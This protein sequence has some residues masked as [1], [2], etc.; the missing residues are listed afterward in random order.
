MYHH[1]TTVNTACAEDGYRVEQSNGG[2]S[3]VILTEAEVQII[4]RNAEQG[5][6]VT[7]PGTKALLKSDGS[8]HTYTFRLTEVTDKTGETEKDGGIKDYTATATAG[9]ADG[10][11][12]FKLSYVQAEL[13]ELPMVFYYRIT[14]DAPQDS[15]PNETFYVA[16]VTL[17]LQDGNLTAA[18]TKMWK[19]GQASSDELSADFTNILTGSLTLSKRVSGSNADDEF[20]FT[21][22]LEPGDS[23]LSQLS[24]EYRAVLSRKDGTTE[25][26]TVVFTDG[27]ANQTLKNGDSL[28]LT[29]IPYGVSWTITETDSKGYLASYTV[30]GSESTEGTVASGIVS[31]GD[32]VVGYTNTML[33]ELPETGG[34]GTYLYTLGGLLLMM[35]AAISLYI[36][37]K[38]R[39]E[40]A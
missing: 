12:A 39:R 4:V 40:V 19:D 5:A 36:H 14:E 7:I 33:Y 16:E 31:S 8:E 15:L 24:N 13:S 23:R 18:V 11:F 25:T 1:M 37:N 6:D 10:T 27:V 9:E 32:T 20:R 26:V 22:E 34:A 2:V 38:R 3:G 35:A 28:K 17:D 21:I 30:N 29:G